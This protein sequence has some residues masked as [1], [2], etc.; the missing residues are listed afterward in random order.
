MTMKVQALPGKI[1]KS[2]SALVTPRD[3]KI[4]KAY[5]KVLGISSKS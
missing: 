5:E 4:L 3:L 2:L 1:E